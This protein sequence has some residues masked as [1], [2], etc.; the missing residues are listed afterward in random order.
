MYKTACN[1]GNISGAGI[2]KKEI[3]AKRDDFG[4]IKN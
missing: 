4:I 2:G 3:F 1:E